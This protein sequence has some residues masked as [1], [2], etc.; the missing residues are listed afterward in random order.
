[1]EL[2]KTVVELATKVE[3][4]IHD[5]DG[6][7]TKIDGV[8]QQISFVKGAVWVI[9]GLIVIASAALAWYLRAGPH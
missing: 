8:R 2:Q 9:G 4:L 1:M 6:H 3:R 7:G 5:V